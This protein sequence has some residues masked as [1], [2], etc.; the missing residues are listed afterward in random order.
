MAGIQALVNQKAGGAQGNPNY[1]YYQLAA[2]EYG[3]TGS[4]VC[5]SSSGNSTGA[6]CIF[7]NVTQ[8][9]NAMNCSGSQNCFGATAAGSSRG[10]HSA[11][12]SANGELSTSDSSP[13]RAFGAAVGWNFATGIG[14]V[15]AYNLVNNWTAGQL[16]HAE[17][18]SGTDRAVPVSKPCFGTLCHRLLGLFYPK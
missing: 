4:S 15:N 5:N 18:E 7:Y 2:S 11:P 12:P 14:T 6:G 8:G 17:K 13:A 1:R 9:D 10:R 3:A 16:R